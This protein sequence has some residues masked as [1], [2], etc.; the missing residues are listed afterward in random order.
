M[1]CFQCPNCR[2]VLQASEA[3]VGKKVRCSDC[4]QVL[5]VPQAA[6]A[7]APSASQDMIFCICGKCKHKLQAPSPFADKQY[8]CVK[9]GHIIEIPDQNGGVSTTGTMRFACGECSQ[10]YCVMAKYAGKKFKC[11]TCQKNCMIP[12][13]KPQ[14]PAKI[15]IKPVSEPDEELYVA[16]CIEED[17]FELVSEENPD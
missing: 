11:L 12:A 1:F 10:L 8:P 15:P 3:Q 17:E 5:V 6:S 16:Q 2:T 4:N 7:A 14:K 13:P 9:C